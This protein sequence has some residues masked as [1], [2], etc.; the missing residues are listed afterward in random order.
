MSKIEKYLDRLGLEGKDKVT[1]IEGT[2]TSI[3]FDLYGCIQV[4]LTPKKGDES[5][6]PSC[7][8]F[9][10]GRVEFQEGFKVM[11]TPNFMEPKKLISEGKKG[12]EFKSTGMSNPLPEYM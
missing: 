6:Y 5:K 2:V 10:I 7:N 4:I 12:P 1:G 8:W 9:D 3:S 11:E